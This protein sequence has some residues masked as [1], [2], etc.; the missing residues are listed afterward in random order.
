M[1][2]SNSSKSKKKNVGATQERRFLSNGE[3]RVQSD[4]NGKKIVGY[5]AKFSPSLSGDLGGFRERLD[6]HCFDACL[7]GNVDCRALWNHSP[8]HILGRTTSGTLRLSVDNVGLRYV[9]D[10]PD[11]QLSRDLM[12]SMERGDVTNS[13]FAFFCSEDAW[14]QDVNGD[15]IRTVLKADLVDVSPV[16]YPA[17]PDATS[18]V[19]AS[20]RS[21]PANLRAK[22][23]RDS[24]DDGH[25]DPDSSDFDPDEDCDDIEDRCECTCESC[26]ENDDC[27]N[28]TNSDCNFDCDGCPIQT[29]RSANMNLLLRRLR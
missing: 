7:A 15:I 28:C 24:D 4:N 29:T 19:R 12:I 23:V 16:T 20:L 1:S 9:I 13:S 25:C 26:S 6:P 17:Y 11:T 22:L 5:A 27:S 18:G 2:K 8:L 3:L 21:C 14:S 10:P